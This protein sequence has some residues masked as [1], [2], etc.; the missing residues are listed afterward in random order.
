MKQ[1]SRDCK[2]S[3]KAG[4][5]SKP[6]SMHNE[7]TVSRQIMHKMKNKY[8]KGRVDT[9]EIPVVSIHAKASKAPATSGAVAVASRPQ[10]PSISA[11]VQT[12]GAALVHHQKPNAAASLGDKGPLLHAKS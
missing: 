3:K 11:Q 5:N 4:N 10:P 6:S 9:Y 12:T 1:R 2:R 7:Q 8:H